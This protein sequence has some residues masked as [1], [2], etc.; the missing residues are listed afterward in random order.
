MFAGSVH[1]VA[2]V[3]RLVRYYDRVSRAQSRV[4]AIQGYSSQKHEAQEI[5]VNVGL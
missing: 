3:G 1:V 2:C 4:M 5:A